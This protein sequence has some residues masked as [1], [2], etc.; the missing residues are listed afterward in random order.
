MKVIDKST[1]M[2]ISD[3]LASQLEVI[4]AKLEAG[5]VIDNSDFIAAGIKKSVI[6]VAVQKLKNCFDLDVL[7]I[8]RG[9]ALVGWILADEVL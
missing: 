8:T 6:T 4:K 7:T 3:K 9:R 5:S 1:G 2:A